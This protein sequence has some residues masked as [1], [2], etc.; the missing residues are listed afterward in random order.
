MDATGFWVVTGLSQPFD[1]DGRAVEV[2]DARLHALSR[3][4]PSRAV[5]ADR[6]SAGEHCLA[7][8]QHVASC[9]VI[10]CAWRSGMTGMTGST[11]PSAEAVPYDQGMVL[12]PRRWCD[13]RPPG[14]PMR[15]LP[16]W[17]MYPRYSHEP[18]D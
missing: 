7:A 16:G 11:P 13:P 12:Y 17:L 3:A 9:W 10:A 18:C 1:L 5:A 2:S 6:A 4:Q 14:S 8:C 15:A